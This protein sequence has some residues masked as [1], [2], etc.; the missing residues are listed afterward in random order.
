MK[1]S[2]KPVVAAL[3]AGFLGSA[4]LAPSARSEDSSHPV[5]VV[6]YLEV[7]P[8]KEKQAQRLIA[9]YVAGAKHASGVLAIDALVRDG[10]P[11]Q[12]ALIEQWQ[13]AKS[14]ED[15]AATAAAQQFRASLSKIESAGVDERI[16]APLYVETEKPAT[17]PPIVVMTHIDII[18]TSLDQGRARIKQLVESSRHQNANLRFDVLVQTNRPNHMTLIEGWKR[19]ADKNAES[20]ATG[21]ISFRHDLLP[22]SGSPYDERTY[23]PLAE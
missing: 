20:A 17:L 6:A 10:Y 22:M 4:A 1:T 15:Y 8:G 7:V 2:F 18:P 5:C 12:F 11:D 14:R 13:S 21:T 23:R 9:D 3:V 16:Q 19:P